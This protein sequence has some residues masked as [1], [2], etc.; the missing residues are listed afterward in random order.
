MKTETFSFLPPFTTE[1]IAKQIQFFAQQGW[2]AGI[3]YCA[4]PDASTAFWNWWKLPMFG[5]QAPAPVLAEIKACQ[6]AHPNSYIRLTA[7]DS[8]RQGQVMAFVV[9]QP[10]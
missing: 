3:E 10:E 9:S 6:A 4:Q 1:Q 5:V 2:I 8:Q 7:Y